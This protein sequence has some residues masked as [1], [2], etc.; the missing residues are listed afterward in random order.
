MTHRKL[1]MLIMLF[2][3]AGCA[4]RDSA[5]GSPTET[6]EYDDLVMD[7]I[8]DVAAEFRNLRK[9]KGHFEGGTWNDDV[10]KWMGRK[11]QLMIQLGS[12]LGAGQH[13]EA[14]VIQLLGPPDLIAGEGDELFDLVNSLPDFEKPA[15]GPYEFLIY[16]WRGTHDFLYFTS[17]GETIINWGWWYAGE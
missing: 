4:V 1:L 13:S 12:R 9:T 14:E 11:H 8:E 15:T 3:L 6:A 17:Q 2:L 7:P 5:P 16:Y 10:D